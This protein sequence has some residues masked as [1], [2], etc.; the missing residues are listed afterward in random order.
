MA[1]DPTASD[2]STPE[3]GT[4]PSSDEVRAEDAENALTRSEIINE[5]GEETGQELLEANISSLS[6][7]MIIDDETKEALSPEAKAAVEAY[8]TLNEIEVH[9]VEDV[10]IEVAD[11]QNDSPV[12]EA[13]ETEVVEEAAEA[14]V[15]EVAEVVEEVPA[16]EG[17]SEEEADVEEAA[18]EAE[19]EAPEEESVSEGDGDEDAD[20]GE[21]APEEAV[22]EGEAAEEAD[23]TS[24]EEDVVDEDVVAVDEDE[25]EE[26]L[27]EH[28]HE[29]PSPMTYQEAKDRLEEIPYTELREMAE[30]DGLKPERSKKGV[31]FQ[32]LSHWFPAPP[33]APD[34]EPPMSV[35][36]RR[37]KESQSQ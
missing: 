27:D 29:T 9:T 18:E 11:D 5:F 24:V 1:Q 13:E 33:V 7:L 21:G 34:D 32:L 10:T 12:E 25:V 19:G 35:R 36:I 17:G 22:A 37:I 3:G 20:S 6:G 30:A 14:E 28:E 2:V 8:F 23:A 16:E 4:Y 31:I 15:A 26:G